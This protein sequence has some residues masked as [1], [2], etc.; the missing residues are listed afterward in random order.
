MRMNSEEPQVIEIEDVFVDREKALQYLED[1]LRRRKNRTVEMA[2]RITQA[3]GTGKTRLLIEFIKKMER[4]GKAVG[5][6]IN[7]PILK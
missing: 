6:F 1:E 2:I 5:L 7:S 4:E 3:P